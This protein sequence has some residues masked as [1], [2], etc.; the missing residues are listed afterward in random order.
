MISTGLPNFASRTLTSTN[1]ES[2]G[3]KKFVKVTYPKSPAE[4]E[5]ITV[6]LRKNFVFEALSERDLSE[7]VD[8][9]ARRSVDAGSQLIRQGDTGDYFYVIEKG[10]YDIYVN[11]QKVVSFTRGQSFGELALLSGEKRAC[12]VQCKTDCKLYQLS[13]PAFQTLVMELPTDSHTDPTL[14]K[15]S[16][17]AVI[18]LYR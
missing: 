7:V 11:G 15:E 9:M 17:E 2:L 6:A 5:L 8:C 16:F 14:W 10:D 18:G 13:R 1:S 12:S 4:R 3:N